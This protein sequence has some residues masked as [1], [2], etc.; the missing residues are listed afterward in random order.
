MNSVVFFKFWFFILDLVRGLVGL[1]D[2]FIA[3]LYFYFVSFVV[4]A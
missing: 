3:F 2:L 4:G 1:R